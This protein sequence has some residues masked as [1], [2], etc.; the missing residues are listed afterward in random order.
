MWELIELLKKELAVVILGATPIFEL[1]GAI[2]LGVSLGFSPFHSTMLGIAGNIL[3]VPFLLFFLRPIF[4]YL[5]RYSFFDRMIVWLENRTLKRSAKMK[6]YTILGLYLLVAVPLP[7]TGAYTG[8]LAATLF[9]LRFKFAF[10]AIVAGII[11]AGFIM[12]T[13]S[14]VGVWMFF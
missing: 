10:P 13:L 14:T 8:C 6:K 3:P 4:N 7:T 1:R 12:Y 11:T 5:R 2:P 9:N